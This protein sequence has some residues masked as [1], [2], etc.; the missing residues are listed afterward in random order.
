MPVPVSVLTIDKNSE[1]VSMVSD[2]SPDTSAPTLTAR[3][4]ILLKKCSSKNKRNF[5]CRNALTIKRL[6]I[7]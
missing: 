3:G 6:M 2:S 4:R 1:K 7:L 5:L